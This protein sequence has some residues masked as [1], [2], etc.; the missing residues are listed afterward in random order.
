MNKSSETETR[1][2]LRHEIKMI[3]RARWYLPVLTALRLNGNGIRPLYPPRQVQSLYL[4]SPHGRALRD[5]L[6]GISYRQKF[7][8][9][10]YG[11]SERRVRGSLECKVRQ[12]TLGWK[13]VLPLRDPLDVA[14][15]DRCCFIAELREQ[16]PPQWQDRVEAQEPVQWL[17]YQREYLATSDGKLRI[18]IDRNLQAWDQRGH[19]L[20]A[21]QFPTPT[22][23]V[24][25]IEIKCGTEDLAAA[26]KLADRLPLAVDKCS[27][28][29]LASMVGHGSEGAIL[30]Q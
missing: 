17:S 9:R 21:S 14:G 1:P 15:Q 22:P 6:A 29:V 3:G 23:S 24:V 27:K 5:N 10:W 20:L 7:R 12:N 28:F 8:F 30:I 2:G 4:D 26:Q 13:Y 11:P 18:T 25:I 16:L 19:F